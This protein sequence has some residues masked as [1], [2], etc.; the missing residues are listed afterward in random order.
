MSKEIKNKEVLPNS[1]MP[2]PT[3]SKLKPAERKVYDAE[4]DIKRLG[5]KPTEVI[6][7]K[8]EFTGQVKKIMLD[9]RGTTEEKLGIALLDPK[10]SREQKDS[11]VSMYLFEKGKEGASML[12]DLWMYKGS[13]TKE[14]RAFQSTMRFD[15]EMF[16]NT[17]QIF[18]NDS[19]DLIFNNLPVEIVEVKDKEGKTKDIVRTTRV[20][21]TEELA[22]TM[23]EIGRY[24]RMTSS[25]LGKRIRAE[26]D[27]RE[28]AKGKGIYIGLDNK[29]YSV[30]ED[31]DVVEVVAKDKAEADKQKHD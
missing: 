7:Y 16:L 3:D 9:R 6:E 4:G 1:S 21:T 11:M 8:D 13:H 20:A 14:S 17:F 25:L 28:R 29:P 23:G 15:F 22:I 31:G 26:V 30:F 27:K 12:M 24:F 19:A 2:V 10:V 5:L 18:M